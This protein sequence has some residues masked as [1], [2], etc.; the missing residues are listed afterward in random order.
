MKNFTIFLKWIETHTFHFAVTMAALTVCVVSVTSCAKETDKN[1]Y[2]WRI[3][4][5][6]VLYK[7][8]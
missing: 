3:E 5:D 6:K 8:R 4:R 1:H 2:L 7:N